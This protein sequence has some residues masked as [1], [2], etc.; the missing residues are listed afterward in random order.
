[1]VYRATP[2]TNI[3]LSPYEVVFGRRMSLDIDWTIPEADMDNC[4][5]EQYARQIG[6]KL[7]V[8]K[9]IAMRNAQSSAARHSGPHNELASLPNYKIG[10]RVLLSDTT[11]KKGESIK[12]K[13]RYA[14]P[15]VITQCRP[16][17]NYRLQH[18]DTGK[19]LKRAVHADRLRPFHELPNDYRLKN[20]PDT[21]EVASNTIAGQITW[22]VTV[23]N[24]MHIDARAVVIGID[25]QWQLVGT[26]NSNGVLEDMLKQCRSNQDPSQSP[27]WNKIYIHERNSIFGPE[28]VFFA[29]APDLGTPYPDD[30]VRFR[31]ALSSC[32]AEANKRKLAS[33]VF[34][35]ILAESQIQKD[36]WSIA[37][38]IAEAL[39]SF[40]DN[41]TDGVLTKIEL[42]CQSILEA[43]I[44]ATVFQQI[45]KDAVT[46]KQPST[47][48][49]E[50]VPQSIKETKQTT[51]WYEI[52]CVLKRRKQAGGDRFL[53]RWKD[54]KEESWVKRQDLSPAAIQHFYSQHPKRQ[55]RHRA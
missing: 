35:S 54:S 8:L 45:L 13:R 2:T 32:M 50:N 36:A 17:F 53:V 51:E 14:G 10:D 23:G 31:Q 27:D 47:D 42:N 6:P 37:Q 15:F 48:S 38:T 4:S 30:S 12:L 49:P 22:R 33:I 1:M 18:A 55:R 21:I 29:R 5:I 24:P 20:R 40:A 19:D 3:G 28:M 25:D 44:F 9:T 46:S 41:V 16:G 43:D 52:D 39:K 26:H 11:V 7:E 34:A